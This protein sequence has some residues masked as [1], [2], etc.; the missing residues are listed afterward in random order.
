MSWIEAL[1][2][3]GGRRRERPWWMFS[4]PARSRARHVR[5]DHRVN[6]LVEQRD[7][8]VR[9]VI[10]RRLERAGY[11]VTTCGGPES[12]RDGCPLLRGR[13][14]A[15]L[16]DADVV[17]N[18]LHLGAGTHRA[19]LAAQRRARSGG[20]VVEATRPQLEHFADLVEGCE[21]LLVPYRSTDV[22]VAVD[23]AQR[24]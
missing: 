12:Q 17:V 14:C 22:L 2:A 6:V 9:D 4:L 21:P 1:A 16:D 13:R 3:G 20:I 5:R 11:R 23:R 24:A 15:L 19:I 8:A 7:T 10:E 18:S